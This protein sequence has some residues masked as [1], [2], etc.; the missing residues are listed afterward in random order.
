MSLSDERI[1]EIGE[2][3]GLYEVS[4][5]DV[6]PRLNIKIVKHEGMGF[7]GVANLEV[8]GK[9]CASFYRSL[10]IQD[11]KE[12]AF[13][14]ALRGFFAFYSKEAEVRIVKDW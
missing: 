9:G 2:V 14:D 5:E 7:M 1:R 3:V 12:K 4:I 8:K 11:T 13:E 6:E 10:Y